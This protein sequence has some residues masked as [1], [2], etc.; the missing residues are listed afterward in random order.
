MYRRLSLKRQLYYFMR[1]TPAP[2][3]RRPFDLSVR[4]RARAHTR[5]CALTSFLSSVFSV[6]HS[7][8]LSSYSRRIISSCFSS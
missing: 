7:R 8:S 5:A 3:I 1:V 6:S 4:A 2:R